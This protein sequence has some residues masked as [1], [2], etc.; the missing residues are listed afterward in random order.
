VVA[1]TVVETTG[2]NLVDS[3]TDREAGCQENPWLTAA[4]GQAIPTIRHPID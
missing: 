1:N 3:L 2:A 4:A